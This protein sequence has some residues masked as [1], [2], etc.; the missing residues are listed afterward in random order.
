MALTREEELALATNPLTTAN[1]I[2][3]AQGLGSFSGG[4][5]GPDMRTG[6]FGDLG[7]VSYDSN[8]PG[9]WTQAALDRLHQH[10][11]SLSPAQ[12]VE[13]YRALAD[14]TNNG[15]PRNF[16][17][18]RY[19]ITSARDLGYYSAYQTARDVL[20]REINA[21]EFAQ[22]VPIFGNGSP[23]EISAGRAYL[24]Q[25][26]QQERLNP[27]SAYNRQRAGGFS[28]DINT[29]FSDLL[30]RGASQDEI[31]HFGSM[32]SSGQIDA[33]SLRQFVSQL[34]EYTQTQDRMFR[35]DLS[36][37]L[38][39]SDTRSFQRQS[40]NVISDYANRGIY[41]S[42]SLDYALTDLMGKIAEKRQS[43]L[44]D[45]TAK[46]YQGNKVAARD[47]YQ[48]TLNNMF[49]EMGYN[50][51]RSDQLQDVYRDR[52]FDAGDY[53]RQREDYMNFLGSQPRRRSNP[54]AY[55]AQGAMAGSP[56]G[57]WGA[58]IGAGAGLLYGYLDQ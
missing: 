33:Y 48:T 22:I 27:N 11:N 17:N 12:L 56:G 39:A 18:Q 6:P 28:G 20:G 52:S 31:N 24:A 45:L 21:N 40:G 9:S 38:E 13:R 35:D 46:Q 51:R 1:P 26:A 54:F 7:N 15:D 41:N 14:A 2:A 42:P 37:E 44:T 30:K 25:I 49:D 32:L 4:S 23:E 47:D 16:L 50:R 36:K 58:G 57:G 29:I 8:K 3:F 53:Y 55:A 43:Y 10:L 19:G 34:P 5:S